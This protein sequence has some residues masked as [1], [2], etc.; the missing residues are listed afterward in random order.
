MTK[1]GS[2]KETGEEVSQEDWKRFE[3][4]VDAAGKTGRERRVDEPSD[5]EPA[6]KTPGIGKGSPESS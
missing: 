5:D 6:T 4:A 1:K 3:A 2:I